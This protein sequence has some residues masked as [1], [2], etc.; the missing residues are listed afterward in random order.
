M[1]AGFRS[2]INGLRAYAVLVV[3]LYHF[4]VPGFRGGFVGVDVFFVISGFLMA[5]ITVGGLERQGS[6]FSILAFYMARARRIMPAL[7][8]LCVVLLL[9][10]WWLLPP[11]DYYTLGVHAAYSV[12]FLSNVKFWL[13]AGYFDV[14]SHEKWFLHT[15]SLAVEWQFYLLLP[16]ILSAAW[17][18]KA[19]RNS[20]AWVMIA[21]LL[22]SLALS[23]ALTP[24]KPT[25]SFFMLPTRAWEMLVGG[26]LFLTSSRHPLTGR[27]Q[28]GVALAGALLLFVSVIVFDS[29]SPWPGWRATVPVCGA[30]LILMAAQSHA[31]WTGNG[32]A[33]WLGDRS[34]SLYLWHWPVVVAL[35][36]LGYKT[37]PV[38]VVIGLGLTCLL[39]QLS[40][41][42]V[43]TPSR[44][45]LARIPWKRSAVILFFGALA[46]I[47][48][49]AGI[50]WKQGVAGR[51]S[52]AIDVVSLEAR[53][54]NPRERECHPSTGVASPS[55][56]YGGKHLRA[57]LLGDSH[58]DALVTG[59]AA[60]LQSPSD[61]IMQWSYS[62]CPTLQGIH[63]VAVSQN[64]CGAFVD[65]VVQ[66]L[67]TVPVDVPVVVVN[68]HG[69][70]AFGKNEVASQAG[71]P[72]VY[73]SRKYA[74]AE[75]AFMA[76]YAQHLTDTA[77]ALAKTRTVYLVRP[78]PEMGVNVPDAARAMVWGAEP[79]V[80]ISLKEYHA[81]NGFAWAAQ[82]A[83]RAR[84]GVKILDPLPYL[85][86]E[87]SC[88]GAKEGRPLYYD[89]NHLS[90]F[91]NR[92]LIPMYREV[93][94]SR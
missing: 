65:W 75:P 45:L 43:E 5:G 77:C 34:Y 47:V 63:Q 14:A 67:Q 62:A 46:V 51:F 31:W 83:A 49:G 25:G 15:W 84:C 36:Y 4:G 73:F 22:A 30:L 11:S 41:Q 68:R 60:A 40:Y 19:H 12:A 55:C 89:D 35:V 9:G 17:R 6:Q 13:E 64:Q 87:G 54:K 70:Y 16:L 59:M 23:V 7:I 44:R 79:R 88:Y 33:Q 80:S 78:I 26:L 39:G 56:I 29:A 32:V 94:E 48:V 8:A 69:Q 38:A 27:A 53:N 20:L 76:E 85:C 50:R 74:S 82:D 72:W 1:T 18:V 92:A 37:E 91:G 58:A 81:R 61:G 21:G 57:I 93:L 28:T 2:D 10:G 90:E 42:W 3:I 71:I 66:R 86:K 24:M 52:H